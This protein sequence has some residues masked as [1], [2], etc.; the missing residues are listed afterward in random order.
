ML[1]FLTVCTMNFFKF[2]LYGEMLREIIVLPWIC[3]EV[4]KNIKISELSLEY[5]LLFQEKTALKLKVSIW[6][7]WRCFEQQDTP[8]SQTFVSPMKFL[9]KDR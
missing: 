9:V 8:T 1:D 7:L 2:F 3:L 6:L 4:R 5:A